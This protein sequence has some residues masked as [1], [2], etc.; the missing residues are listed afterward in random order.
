[1]RTIAKMILSAAV[2]VLASAGAVSTKT[3]KEEASKSALTTEWIRISG[4]SVNCDDVQVDCTPVNNGNLCMYEDPITS[5][6]HQVFRK[7]AAQQCAV[8]LYKEP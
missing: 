4:S 5:E 3:A 2:F 6:E 8:Q 1:M 7:N